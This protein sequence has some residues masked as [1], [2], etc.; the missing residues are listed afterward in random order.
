MMRLCLF[1]TC[2]ELSRLLKRATLR[3]KSVSSKY[4]I[5]R[6][7]RFQK[8]TGS[9]SSAIRGGLFTYTSLTRETYIIATMWHRNN[10]IVGHDFEGKF[11]FEINNAS[12]KRNHITSVVEKDFAHAKTVA[13]LSN[14]DDLFVVEGDCASVWKM[15]GLGWQ[16]GSCLLATDSI[17]DIRP[18]YN[19]PLVAGRSPGGSLLLWDLRR[20]SESPCNTR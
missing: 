14:S 13:R 16:R 8:K 12:D 11:W 20:P 6:Q 3:D 9:L 2:L 1:G 4:D 17:S 10:I 18:V 15:S 5:A 19:A 7:S